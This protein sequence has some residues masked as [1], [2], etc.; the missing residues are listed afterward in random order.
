MLP[1]ASLAH[2]LA[3]VVVTSAWFLSFGDE[4]QLDPASSI[5][6]LEGMAAVLGQLSVGQLAELSDV[7]REL[8]AQETSPERRAFLSSFLGELGIKQPAG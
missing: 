3:D 2:A 4:R 7:I 1:Y 5:R 8:A 6:E